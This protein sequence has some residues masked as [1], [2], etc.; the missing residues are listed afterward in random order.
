MIAT[1]QRHSDNL[2]GRLV[3]PSSR[4]GRP[5][6]AVERVR[7]VRGL[8]EPPPQAVVVHGADVALAVARVDHGA[9]VGGVGVVADPA[10]GT[11]QQVL[12]RR[13][14]VKLG[15]ETSE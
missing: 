8:D 7:V 3:L 10:L 11:A 2:P 15:L 12:C 4:V 1:S 9:R 13:N 5:H 14:N 6:L